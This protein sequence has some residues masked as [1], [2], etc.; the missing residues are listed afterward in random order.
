MCDLW[1]IVI[2]NEKKKNPFGVYG[3]EAKTWSYREKIT[4][5]VIKNSLGTEDNRQV[6]SVKTAAEIWE[7]LNI[8]DV[9]MV[10]QLDDT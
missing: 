4:R 2:G 1:K 6:Q 8:S 3:S 5:V 10:S 9:A 7:I